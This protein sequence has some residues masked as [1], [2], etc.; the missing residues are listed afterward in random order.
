M[1][2]FLDDSDS[3]VQIMP[4]IVAFYP[5]RVILGHADTFLSM[6]EVLIF[7]PKC[8]DIYEVLFSTTSLDHALEAGTKNYT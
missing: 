3:L 6:T 2:S 4:Y 5:S 1:F 7:K 8:M